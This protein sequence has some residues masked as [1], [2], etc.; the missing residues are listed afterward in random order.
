MNI[1]EILTRHVADRGD[2]PAIIDRGGPLSFGQL[3]D[4]SAR[5]AAR[6]EALGLQAGATAL[7]LCP[8]SADLYI[9]LL[10]VFRLGAVAMF[11][12][13]SAGR[14]HLERCCRLLPPDLFI[15]SAK[16]QLLRLAS[17]AVRRI[18]RHVVV[19]RRLPGM[20]SLSRQ[21]T[22]PTR[23]VIT[24][25][26]ADTPALVTF[27]SGS[28][29]EPK[30]AVRTHGFLLAQ[31]EVLRESLELAPGEMDLT[32]LPIF[33]LANLA[34]GVTSVIPDA[35]LRR[36]GAIAPGPV[37]DQID[38]LGPTRIAASPALLD[39]LAKQ[40]QAEG[41][42]LSTFRRI[43]TGGAPVFPSLLARL[44]AVAP[45]AVVTAV[46]GSTEAE[47]IAHVEWRTIGPDDLRAMRTGGGLLTGRPV[48]AIEVRIL[49]DHWGTPIAPMA[50][51]QL[52]AMTL[53]AGSAGE[54]VVHGAHVLTGYLHGRGDEE[55]KFDVDGRRWHRTGD[56]GYFDTAGRLW[57]LGRCAARID[58]RCGRL[59]PF[60]VECAV[61]D[62]EGVRRTAFVAHG[63]RRLL[64]VELQP[65]AA[66]EATLAALREAIAWAHADDAIV[67]RA[68]PLDARHNAKI[69]YPALRALLDRR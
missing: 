4:A 9:T 11:V 33:V 51:R 34:S 50:A 53:P 36:P 47:P 24:R 10:G 31:H 38:R 20:T 13:P 69:D 66:R 60:T 58:D 55:T 45:E 44:Q 29:G 61:E 43:F 59:Y 65:E 7:I 68:L 54:I 48:S 17:R 56:A 1:V 67:V 52:D 22:G 27:T 12:D 6:L 8:M 32:T 19:G 63:G 21:M 18:A 14:A 28:T 39:R 15:G 25:V 64:V 26:D 5:V 49:P 37:L 41:L 16:A 35:D 57:L 3:D 42:R 40:A 23:D 2:R 62:L 30:A 46:Y